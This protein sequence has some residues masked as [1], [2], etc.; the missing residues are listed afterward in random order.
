MTNKLSTIFF[1]GLCPSRIV[2]VI[3]IYAAY[4]A[5]MANAKDNQFITTY[6]DSTPLSAIDPLLSIFYLSISLISRSL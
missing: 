5:E 6:T 4:V 2:K 1:N 3:A